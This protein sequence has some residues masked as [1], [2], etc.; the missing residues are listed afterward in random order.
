M[1]RSWLVRIFREVGLEPPDAEAAAEATLKRMLRRERLLTGAER[2]G[3]LLQHLVRDPLVSLNRIVGKGDEGLPLVD[4]EMGGLNVAAVSDTLG[5][6]GLDPVVA[7]AFAKVVVEAYTPEDL[8]QP[9]WEGL[10]HEGDVD[11][12]VLRR[13]D[14]TPLRKV[15][16]ELAVPA[17]QAPTRQVRVKPRAQPPGS[18]RSKK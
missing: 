16:P 6:S 3:S 7:M 1:D 11:L 12:E 10:G 15:F 18:S 8:Y 17:D 5:Q 13:E 2:K 9:V 4:A 14:W